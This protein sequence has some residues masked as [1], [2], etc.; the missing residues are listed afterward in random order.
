MAFLHSAV[1][2]DSS[3]MPYLQHNNIDG[4]CPTCGHYFRGMS[5][6]IDLGDPVQ[7]RDVGIY[8]VF[9]HGLGTLACKAEHL[10]GTAA[11]DVAE[12][13]SPNTCKWYW[14][15]KAFQYQ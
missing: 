9:F 13:E 1:G 5:V 4:V 8:W 6:V 15:R 7:N 3:I 2:A 10:D 14:Q 11:V 12:Q